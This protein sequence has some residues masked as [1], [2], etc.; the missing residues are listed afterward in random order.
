MNKPIKPS[1]QPAD[2][3]PV[4]L[5]YRLKTHTFPPGIT[6]AEAVGTLGL[7]PEQ[8]LAILG[9]EL[10]QADR[11]LQPGDQIQLISVISGG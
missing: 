8:V 3:L 6:L 4:Q 5:T 10:V 1:P 2:M 7:V 11:I 9:G